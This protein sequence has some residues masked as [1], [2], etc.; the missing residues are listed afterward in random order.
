MQMNTRTEELAQRFDKANNE[1]IGLI[2]RLD[3]RQWQARCAAEGWT[4]A[5]AACHLA[6]DH[7]VLADFVKLPADGKP[8][9]D[10]TLE[11]VHQMN[12]EQAARNATC[13]K[14]QVIQLLRE[15]GAAAAAMVRELTDAQLDNAISVPASHPFR[16]LDNLPERL[17]PVMGIEAGLIGHI[18]EHGSSILVAAFPA[19][20]GQ[21][22]IGA[23]HPAAQVPA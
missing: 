3:E 7:A 4:V 9:P 11:A 8:L 13:T 5:Q 12:A 17:T 19:L 10:F 1:F 6:E 21:A 16:V 23:T 18:S 15:N 20:T 14:Q 22:R 2:E